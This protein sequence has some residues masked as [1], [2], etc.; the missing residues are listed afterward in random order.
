MTREEMVDKFVLLFVASD[1]DRA[2]SVLL[3]IIETCEKRAEC[4]GMAA[5]HAIMLTGAVAK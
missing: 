2:R 5:A 4:E 3:D 1:R